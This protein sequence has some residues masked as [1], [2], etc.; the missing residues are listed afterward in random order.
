MRKEFKQTAMLFVWIG[1]LLSIGCVMEPENPASEVTISIAA[2]EPPAPYYRIDGT[3]TSNAEYSHYESKTGAEMEKDSW[4]IVGIFNEGTWEF[5][6]HALD[7][8][9]PEEEN[10][11][12]HSLRSATRSVVI[13]DGKPVE[14]TLTL[15]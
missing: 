2:E 11:A 6:V 9:V 4:T 3:N 14:V 15:E 7:Q 5:T 10:P 8:H 13:A 1:I 12:T